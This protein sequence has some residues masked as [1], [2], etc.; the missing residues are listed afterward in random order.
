VNEALR[1]INKRRRKSEEVQTASTL[2]NSTLSTRRS[3]SESDTVPS[4][5]MVSF[6]L[7]LLLTKGGKRPQV[8]FDV[9]KSS[10]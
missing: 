4:S 6:I 3:D 5:L 1:E 2:V 7:S 8:A 9:A 10:E